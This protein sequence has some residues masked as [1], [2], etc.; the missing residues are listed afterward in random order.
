MP[1]GNL[2]TAA[3][4]LCSGC[5]PV[6]A[7]N[8][9][10]H[11]GIQCISNRTYNKIQAAYLIPTVFNCWKDHQAKLIQQRQGRP[12]SLGGDGRCC[13]PGHCAKYGSYTLMDLDDKRVLDMQLIQVCRQWG[14]GD[15]EYSNLQ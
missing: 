8:F 12:L 1:L 10:S 4:I 5:S 3:G 14:T 13:S 6:K 15:Y 7:L 2:L 11:I 9:L